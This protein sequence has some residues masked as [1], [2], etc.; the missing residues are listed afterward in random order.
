VDEHVGENGPEDSIQAYRLAEHRG[1][2]APRDPE[3]GQDGGP[4]DHLA[5]GQ[6]AFGGEVAV[7]ELRAEEHGRQ[8]GQV[9][10]PEDQRLLPLGVEPQAGQVAEDQ[11]EPRPPDEELQKHHHRQ[12]ESISLHWVSRADRR[13]EKAPT[14]SVAIPAALVFRNSPTECRGAGTPSQRKNRK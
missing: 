10:R 3:Q 4:A 9:E 5:E 14:R 12:P 13:W 6:E 1:V 2:V 7:G 8:G 11:R